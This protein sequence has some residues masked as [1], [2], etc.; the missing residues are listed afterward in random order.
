MRDTFESFRNTDDINKY[1]GTDI[2]EEERR[3]YTRVSGSG[4]RISIDALGIIPH[5][6][7]QSVEIDHL[8]QKVKQYSDYDEVK[9]ELEIMKVRWFLRGS[10]FTRSPLN[11]VR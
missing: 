9:R 7:L 1:S 8:K 10:P 3:V 5:E 2:E 6:S 11:T 4:E